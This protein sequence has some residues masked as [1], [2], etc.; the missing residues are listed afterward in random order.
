MIGLACS[1]G[2]WVAAEIR[3]AYSYGFYREGKGKGYQGGGRERGARIEFPH[4]YGDLMLERGW[5]LV[6]NSHLIMGLKGW[7]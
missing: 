3:F 5:K 6:L 1:R 7:S 4:G 2:D